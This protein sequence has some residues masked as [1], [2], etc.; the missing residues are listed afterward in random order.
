M[1]QQ[2]ADA[3][4]FISYS[5]RDYYFAESLTLHLLK[6]GIPAWLDVKDLTPGV[7]WERDLSAA[8][9]ASA[10]VV[11]I[12]SAE[13]MKSPNVRQETERAV[14][15][16]KRIIVVR[17]RGAGLPVELQHCELVDFRGAFLPALRDLVALLQTESKAADRIPR[18][19]LGRRS[20][21]WPLWVLSVIVFLSVPTN[22]A[23]IGW[24]WPSA[25]I[26]DRAP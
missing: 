9:D 21:R 6:Q 11:I 22:K 15:Q 2:T 13:S 19:A 24:T 14:K 20:L 16:G 4:V 25:R 18:R 1:T 8:L 12:A 7:F 26:A 23:T 5:R 10:C 17:F 3:A